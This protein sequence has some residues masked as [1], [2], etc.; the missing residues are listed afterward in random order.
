MVHQRP[1]NTCQASTSPGIA[2]AAPPWRGTPPAYW[3]SVAAA[4]ALPPEQNRG[5]ATFG[6]RIHE[7]VR[8]AAE[9]AARRLHDGEHSGHR[10][11]R[12]ERVAAAAQ[13]VDAGLRDERML[14]GDDAVRGKHRS[15][16]ISHTRSID[17]VRR[18]RQSATQRG[19]VEPI[20][21]TVKS[22]K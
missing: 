10:E 1:A 12:V 17:R 6:F 5:H 13:H 7:D 9:M 15:A 16:H 18:Q 4:G 22:A 21:A 19:R 14:G 2:D 11:R 3:S 20:A 8:I